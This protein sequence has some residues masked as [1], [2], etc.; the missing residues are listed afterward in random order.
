M[1]PDEEGV[2]LAMFDSAFVDRDVEEGPLRGRSE[3]V[4]LIPAEAS[5]AVL[6][7]EVE[8]PGLAVL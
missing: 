2:D 5:W 1:E 7:L 6:G 3:I 4:G 8:M